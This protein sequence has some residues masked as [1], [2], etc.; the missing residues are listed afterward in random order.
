MSLALVSGGGRRVDGGSSEAISLLVARSRDPG[1]GIHCELGI[2]ARKLG[3]RGR[4]D[5]LT[6]ETQ[7]FGVVC[8][9]R[10]VRL[11]LRGLGEGVKS[12]GN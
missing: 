4:D 6:R 1:S 7:E 2:E 5:A 3:K 12:L 9:L 11:S 8:L 10:K